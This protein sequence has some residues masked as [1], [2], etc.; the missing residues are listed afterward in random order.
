MRCANCNRLLPE[1]D[2]ICPACVNRGK[3]MLRITRF[4]AAVSDG[5]RSRWPCFRWRRRR[6]NLA[7]PW[8]LQG[9]II[10]HVLDAASEYGASF[11]ADGRSGCCSWR[12]WNVRADCDGAAD[13]VSG[14]KHIAADLRSSVYRAIEFLQLTYFDKKQVGSD[15]EP[16]HA[17][18]R[19]GVGLSG[20]RPAL[21]RWRTLLLLV[22]ITGFL[23]ATSVK[24][25]LRRPVADSGDFAD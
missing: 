12:H 5:R 10:D 9:E 22:G 1:K 17:G 20:G 16:G 11:R 23:F 4:L 21:S 6:L 25:A 2:G 14:G 13:R 8:I 15:H 19:P 7:P 18:H 3:T 24:L